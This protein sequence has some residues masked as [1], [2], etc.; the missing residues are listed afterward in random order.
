MQK[1][2]PVL[3]FD[4]RAQEA[5]DFYLSVFPKSK[6]GEIMRYPEGAPNAGDVAT[7]TFWLEDQQF[8]ILNGGPHFKMTEAVS[9]QIMTDDQAE[10]DRYWTALTADGGEES[11]CGWLKDKFGVS[12]QVTPR[13]LMELMTDRDQATAG[14]VMQAM[15]QM[16]KIDIP[17]LEEAAKG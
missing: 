8:T 5:V 1:I 6:A 12:W 15:M 16:R 11:Q 13:R 17:A 7:A 10:T 4:G 14:R 2:A 9:F 3:W